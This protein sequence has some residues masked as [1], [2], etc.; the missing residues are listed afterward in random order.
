[1]TQKQDS[2]LHG[3][4][5]LQTLVRSDKQNNLQLLLMHLQASQSYRSHFE[6]LIDELGAALDEID[7]AHSKQLSHDT[8]AQDK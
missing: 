6:E 7:N 4:S 2:D 5:T 8:H 1:M 3:R